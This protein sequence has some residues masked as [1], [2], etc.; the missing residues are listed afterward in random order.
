M[1]NFQDGEE[2]RVIK[3]GVEAEV[4]VF[5]QIRDVVYVFDKANRAYQYRAGDLLPAKAF[6][7]ETHETAMS[8]GAGVQL[9]P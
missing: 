8:N 5:R 6:Y 2:A 1:R 7:A 9:E 3:H 4:T